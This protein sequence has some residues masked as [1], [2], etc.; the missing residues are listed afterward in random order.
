MTSRIRIAI[1]ALLSASAAAGG[2]SIRRLDGSTISAASADSLARRVLAEHA[3]TG[4]QITVVNDAAIVWS[5]A[6]GLRHINPALPMERGTVTWAAS[7]TKGVFAT[8]VTQLVERGL[9]DL[10]I[11]VAKQLPA[12]LDTYEQYRDIGTE[13]VHDPRWPAITPRILLAHTSGLGN[14]WQF[15][16]DRKLH[17][18]FEP[19][20]RFSYSGD[21]L[22]LVQFVIEQKL[23]K[24]LD[25]LM[26]DAIFT[27]FGMSN[28]G[29]IYRREF[30]QNVS[31]RF[32]AAGQFLAQTRRY[33]ARGAGSMMSTA[34]DIATFAVALLN[35]RVLS[36]AT[37]AAM[38][39][40]AVEI[41]TLHQFAIDANEGNGREA[42]EVGLA[43]GLGWGL[44]TTTR[45]GP[46]FFKEGHGDG[47]QNYMICF[48]RARSCMV[49]LTNSDN[50]ELAFRPLL[51]GILGDT[52]TPWEWEGYTAEYIQRQRSR[53]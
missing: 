25:T 45:Y 50:G 10:D 44:L 46:A 30:E 28:S 40:P 3:V 52:V 18:F 12:P 29:M 23:G 24:H 14:L 51:E 11:P 15:S 2:Q 26:A 8:Y 37:R 38:L 19:G 16:P 13:L 5:A 48:E 43:Y 47:A 39:A 17:I 22:N 1:M 27:P 49:I 34:D 7:I 32:G 9:F 53:Q 20:S 4:A 35:G 21:G 6:Y 41:R 36:A 33:P 31:D 42:Q